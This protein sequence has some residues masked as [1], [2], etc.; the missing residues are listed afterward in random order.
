MYIDDEEPV[1]AVAAK[2][3][4]V[5]HAHG[6][7]VVV[8]RLE[9]REVNAGDVPGFRGIGEVEDVEPAPGA[10]QFRAVLGRVGEIVDFAL[11][12]P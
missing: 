3:Q 6:P 7:I 12:M 10:D 4:A 5:G 11:P 2:G 9:N 8:S 1:V